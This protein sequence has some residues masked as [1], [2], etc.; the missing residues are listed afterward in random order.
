MSS[1]DYDDYMTL[2]RQ[3]VRH[4]CT[5]SACRTCR[6]YRCPWR[7]S[8]TLHALC[9]SY[10]WSLLLFLAPLITAA[11]ALRV[12]CAGSCSGY[13]RPIPQTAQPAYYLQPQPYDYY[14][15]PY[16]YYG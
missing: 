9:A 4:C 15:Q 8:S 10:L 11:R 7:P 13:L 2:K 5:R 16:E 6:L 3:R 12:I 1:R 14:A